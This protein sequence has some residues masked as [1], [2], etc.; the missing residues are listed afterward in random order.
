MPKREIAAL[1]VMFALIVSFITFLTYINE[2]KAGVW[3]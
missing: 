1:A 3:S 2:L